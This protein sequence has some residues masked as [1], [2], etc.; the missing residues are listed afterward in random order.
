MVFAEEEQ[1]GEGEEG[2]VLPGSSGGKVIKVD[3]S[4]VFN[5]LETTRTM[6]ETELGFTTMLQAYQLVQVR[7]RPRL[8]NEGP[9]GGAGQ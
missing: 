5:Q 8:G 4:S 2:V 9:P 3:G 1:E 6:L 7:N